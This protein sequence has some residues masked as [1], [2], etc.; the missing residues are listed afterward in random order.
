MI[1]SKF[2]YMGLIFLIVG[3]SFA[4]CIGG[5][6]K[7]SQN[8]EQGAG[9]TNE[10]QNNNQN[11]SEEFASNETNEQ[12]NASQP[13]GPFELKLYLYQ[14]E[15][16]VHLLDAVQPTASE[17]SSAD[18]TFAAANPPLTSMGLVVGTWASNPL[19]SSFIVAGKVSIELYAISTAAVGLYFDITPTKV[20]ENLPID[21][22]WA[23]NAVTA[24]GGTAQK[25]TGEALIPADSPWVFKK[26][27]TFEI[28][29][30]CRGE[31][32]FPGTTKLVYG[33]TASPAN[34]LMPSCATK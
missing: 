19:P 30:Y 1:P 14:G 17:D 5:E 33:S 13:S 32:V 18:C 4:G 27:D 26:G 7:T 2:V 28:S 25:L 34:V 22:K 20:G 11:A 12:N 6:N 16:D 9:Q 31:A 29:I 8:Q 10:Q 3:T 15:G 23:T 21:G 24:T